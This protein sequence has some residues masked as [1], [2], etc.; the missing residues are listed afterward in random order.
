MY[1]IDSSKHMKLSKAYVIE[2]GKHVKLTKAYV[3]EN[4]K[5]VKLWS[6][7]DMS[8]AVRTN[9][10][11]G[12]QQ[13]Y[14]GIYALNNEA[15]SATGWNVSSVTTNSLSSGNGYTL[16]MRQVFANSGQFYYIV[17]G[18]TTV[19]KAYTSSYPSLKGVYD[20]YD[21]NVF[22]C[23]NMTK[24]SSSSYGGSETVMLYL[25]P[26]DFSG[27][28]GYNT[29]I[30]SFSYSSGSTSGS[31]GFYSNIVTHKGKVY[32]VRDYY[33]YQTNGTTG[34]GTHTFS[35]WQATIDSSYSCTEKSVV[36]SNYAALASTNGYDEGGLWVVEVSG[37]LFVTTR[38]NIYRFNDSDNTLTQVTTSSIPSS[39]T[40][41]YG[42]AKVQKVSENTFL[43]YDTNVGKTEVYQCNSS[44][45]LTKL[46]TFSSADV[47]VPKGDMKVKASSTYSSKIV[48][49]VSYSS[50]YG[51]TW[52]SN[53]IDADY[54]TAKPYNSVTSLPTVITG[55]M[56]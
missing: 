6:G 25:I 28:K 18:S 38:G 51:E 31:Y 11:P 1:A 42:G 22:M 30:G 52:T 24:S 4:G 2:N 33:S 40:S 49:T 3:I 27:T 13:P 14:S 44:G 50:N 37:Y 16:G 5:H 23:L 19:T 15:T 7:A 46:K 32:Y 9:Y 54:G 8:V 39:G 55:D 17:N 36:V 12:Y 53:T 20:S 34:S 56:Y 41:V 29:N 45:T 48:T 10:I 35:L 43:Y 26:K 47:G 21:D